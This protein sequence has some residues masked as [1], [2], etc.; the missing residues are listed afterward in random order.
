MK[1]FWA[2]GQRRLMPQIPWIIGFTIAEF[3]LQVI[4]NIC[5][6]TKQNIIMI[7]LSYRNVTPC[8]RATIHN[9]LTNK[10]NYLYQVLNEMKQLKQSMGGLKL[11]VFGKIIIDLQKTV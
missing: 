11:F 3:K 8:P 7:W 2:E 5:Q 10:S 9:V 4:Q 1:D 6:K